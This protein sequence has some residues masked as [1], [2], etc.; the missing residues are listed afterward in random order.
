MKKHENLPITAVSAHA[1]KEDKEKSLAD[2][3]NDH[4][5]KSTDLDMR[6]MTLNKWLKPAYSG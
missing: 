3:V 4:I 5:T 2:G 1:M 6:I